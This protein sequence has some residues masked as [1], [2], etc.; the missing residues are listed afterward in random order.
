[1]GIRDDAK[2][3]IGQKRVCVI[4]AGPSGTAVLRAFK[5]AKDKG[6]DIPEVVCFEKQA[7]VG[8]QWIYDWRVGLDEHLEPVPSAMY[9]YLW[10]NGPKECLEFADY[11]FM[12]HFKKPIPSYPP[13]EVL[14]DY[15]KGRI[16]K[17]NVR[18][19]IHFNT[20]VHNVRFDDQDDDGEGMFHVT[21]R[22]LSIEDGIPKTTEEHGRFDYVFCC[23][24]HFSK[25]NVPYFPGFE[26]FEGRILHSVHFKDACEFTDSRILII[27][28]SY[29]AEDIASQCYKY[30]CRDITCS[31]RTAPMAFHWPDCFTT[32]PL[33]QKVQGKTATFID[34]ST[35]D[36]DAIILCTGYLHHFPFLEQS[37]QLHTKNRLWIEDC[38][39]GIFWEPNPR[40]MYIGMQD[41]WLTFNMFDAQAWVARDWVLGRTELPSAEER[42]AHFKK[43]RDRE[44]GLKSD[45]DMIRFQTDYTAELV[46]ETDYPSFNYEG[47]A[48]AF[49]DWEHSK[50]E[51]IMTFR[52]KPHK[53]VMDGTMAPVHHTTWLEA[54]DDSRECY[55]KTG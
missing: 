1:M 44:E 33:L 24:G 21:W 40:L 32:R 37:L 35:K 46:E 14:H 26:R 13:R 42:A 34:G 47:V 31:Y 9:R 30:G 19:W 48:Q 54:L 53:S 2:K 4:G 18:H 10:S 11:T 45:E 25:P 28:T 49:L 3:L 27:G 5:S 16:E 17:A 22:H 23:V 43:W 36:I 29:S 6:A 20:V 15:I 7:D 8:G 50:H 55:L 51:N 39:K 52:D 38:Y 12:E 41:Q